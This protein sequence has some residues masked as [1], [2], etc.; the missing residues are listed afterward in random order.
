MLSLND[1]LMSSKRHRIQLYKG[2]QFDSEVPLAYLK[3]A[4]QILEVSDVL[5]KLASFIM[6]VSSLITNALY[7]NYQCSPFLW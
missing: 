4:F 7:F 6:N 3:K 2:L 5:M 1:F